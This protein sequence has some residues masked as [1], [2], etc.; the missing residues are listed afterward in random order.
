MV[1]R[2][3]VINLSIILILG[4]VVGISGYY[5]YQNIKNQIDYN[6]KFSIYLQYIQDINELYNLKNGKGVS[7]LKEINSDFVGWISCKDAGIEMPLVQAQDESEEYYINHNFNRDA[8]YCGVPYVRKEHSLYSNNSTNATIVG[9][10]M[11][12]FP[13][14]KVQ[15]F[16]NLYE[17]IANAKKINSGDDNSYNFIVN[18]ETEQKVFE[19]KI[20]SVFTFNIRKN[21]DEQYY[22]YNSNNLNSSDEFNTFYTTAKNL[23]VINSDVTANYGDSFISLFTCSKISE[24][25]RVMAVAKLLN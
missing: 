17:Y 1:K 4:I 10:S 2:K 24:D 15:I 8:N 20:F 18:I 16:S 23:S 25:Y 3:V 21:Y 13:N 9:H 5:L 14:G 11:F 19:Y 6:R 12:R 7:A 22:I